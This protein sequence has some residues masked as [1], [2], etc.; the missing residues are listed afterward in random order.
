MS[1]IPSSITFGTRVVLASPVLPLKCTNFHEDKFS[2]IFPQIREIKSS[3]DFSKAL[4]RE[5]KSSRDFSKALNS[6]DFYKKV[7]HCF[8]EG[9]ANKIVTVQASL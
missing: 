9:M 5:S 8:I 6:Q 3:R 1:L 4:I 7:S 2:R